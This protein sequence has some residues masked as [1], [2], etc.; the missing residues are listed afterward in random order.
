METNLTRKITKKDYNFTVPHRQICLVKRTRQSSRS[1]SLQKS[2]H[3]SYHDG[4]STG[5][6]SKDCV[7]RTIGK[8]TF[9]S[10]QS[11]K[12]KR[13]HDQDME[14]VRKSIVPNTLAKPAG[15]SVLKLFLEEDSASS[16]EVLVYLPLCEQTKCQ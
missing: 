11:C 3:K 13:R 8:P 4:S 10:R 16:L 1:G 5:S 2:E 12:H 6:S 7:C 9:A 14:S 15:S